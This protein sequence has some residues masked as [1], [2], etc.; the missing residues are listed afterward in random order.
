MVSIE[1]KTAALYISA[2][3]GTFLSEIEVCRV[4]LWIC[5]PLSSIWIIHLGATPML[6]LLIFTRMSK[7]L[8]IL[9]SLY[10]GS[11][12][13]I[14][15]INS[16]HSPGGLTW[17]SHI[18]VLWFAGT[19]GAVGIWIYTT[20]YPTQVRPPLPPANPPKSSVDN[21]IRQLQSLKQKMLYLFLGALIGGILSMVFIH[22]A[23]N[24][25][26]RWDHH[27]I[28]YDNLLILL[29]FIVIGTCSPIIIFLAQ[30]KMNRSQSIICSSIVA[31]FVAAINLI[32]GEF[33][34]LFGHRGLGFFGFWFAGMLAAFAALHVQKRWHLRQ[35]C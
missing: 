21:R 18:F 17:V 8:L 31:S 23:E 4:D 20:I 34:T 3:I 2:L 6:L 24:T 5:N 11:T 14:L 30:L 16:A 27:T 33:D 15:G 35:P 25:S 28:T 13:L 12:L 7:K 26:S 19:A 29:I 9:A 32:Y 22:D 1:G 10:V